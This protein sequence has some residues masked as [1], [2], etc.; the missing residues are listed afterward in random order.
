MREKFG[1][2]IVSPEAYESG[3]DSESIE[4]SVQDIIDT[5]RE[6]LLI[7]NEPFFTIDILGKNSEEFIPV[8][9]AFREKYQVEL[10]RI[11][12]CEITEN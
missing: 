7:T 5:F 6:E 4:N 2:V 10:M 11:V 8:A 1:F 12:K 9:D 3:V